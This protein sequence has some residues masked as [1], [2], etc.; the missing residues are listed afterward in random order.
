MDTPLFLTL[1]EVLELHTSRIQRYGGLQGVRDMGLLQSALAMPGSKFGGQYHHS[2]N[3]HMA[4]AYLYHIVRNHPFV[5]GNKR[6]GLA[7]AL[8]FLDMN[9]VEFVPDEDAEVEM[10]LKVAENQATKDDVAAYFRAH[11][12]SD[13]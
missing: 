2:D 3:P 5:D 12:V 8:V 6:T 9:G 1:E 10:T 11:I 4:A 7:A 13:S